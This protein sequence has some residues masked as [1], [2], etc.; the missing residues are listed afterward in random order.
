MKVLVI[1]GGGREHALVWK[2]AQSPKV[3]KI[4][5]APGNGGIGELAMNVPIPVSDLEGLLTF[6]KEEA[7][8]LTVVGPEDPMVGGIVDRFQAEGLKIFGVHRQAA[9]LEGSKDVAKDF[10][11]RHHIPT[12]TYHTCRSFEEAKD[13]LAFYDYPVVIKADGLCLGKGVFICETEVEAIEALEHIFVD[14]I[15][16]DEGNQVVIETFLK[17]IEASLLCLVHEKGIVPMESAKDYKQIGEGDVGPNTGGVGCYSPS[18]LFDDAMK[19]RIAKEILAPIHQGLLEDELHFRG[20]LFIGLMIVDG[21]PYVL[22]FNV[23][24]G[25]PE[26]E[27]VLPRLQSDLVDVLEKTLDDT[28]TPD[29]LAWQQGTCLTVVATSGG[30]PSTYEKGKAITIGNLPQDIVVFHN[31]TKKVDAGYVTAGGR[32]L[33]VTTVGENL[34]TAAHRIYQVMDQV[35]FDGMYYRR[36]IG[37]D[38]KSNI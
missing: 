32:V 34:K 30:Y 14:R 8:D 3:T 17:G 31:G 18:P 2:L 24:F 4:Y 10:M 16:G 35:Q 29:D 33:S 19:E 11:R 37:L 36:D 5:A 6:A 27:V 25:D 26:T 23:R 1:G 20:V 38:E 12:A 15:F 7:I 13:A 21:K 22:E 9:M 28:L